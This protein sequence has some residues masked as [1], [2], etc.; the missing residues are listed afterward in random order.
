M[1][2]DPAVEIM[3]IEPRE[4]GDLVVPEHLRETHEAAWAYARDA[5]AKNTQIAYQKDWAAWLAWTQA[6]G[7]PA[8]PTKPICIAWYASRL[9]TDGK[10]WSTINRA[11]SAIIFVHQSAGHAAG[12]RKHPDLK[13]VLRG[14]LR[15]SRQPRKKDALLPSHM[16]RLVAQLPQGPIGIRD[17]ALLL[18]WWAGAFRRSEVVGLNLADVTERPEGYLI[19]LGKTK[20]DQEGKGYPVGIPRAADVRMCP[21]RA[22]QTWIECLAVHGYNDGPLFRQMDGAG[23]VL[24]NRL[25]D[26]GAARVVKRYA[27]RAGLDHKNVSGH[28]LRSGFVTTMT[29]MDKAPQKIAVQ[30]RH[31]SLNTLMEYVRIA[32]AMRNN[33]G[34]GGLDSDF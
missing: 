25:S 8:L 9:A 4:G 29:L 26:E 1:S 17:H 10:A 33:P 6:N 30:T 3:V 31:R 5:M 22:L 7:L 34:A 27:A 21:V 12:Y 15:S 11:V 2:D 14:I 13:T 24:P 19:M 16:R 28:S 32:D 20:T 23:H 18:V